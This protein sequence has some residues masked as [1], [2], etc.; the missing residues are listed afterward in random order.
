MKP[1]DPTRRA[2]LDAA[3][4]E[5]TPD[6]ATRARVLASVLALGASAAAG[7]AKAASA[8]VAAGGVKAGL[9]FVHAL[10]LAGLAVAGLGAAY[11]WLAHA[12]AVRDGRP[13]A[14]IAASAPT[15]ASPA[16]RGIPPAA[17]FA[18]GVSVPTDPARTP[19]A[20]GPTGSSGP[21]SSVNALD[22]ELS[23]LQGAHRAYR[24]GQAGSALQLAQEHARLF[25]R[26]Q[27]S[28]ERQTIEVLSLC[29]LGRT[30]EARAVAGKLRAVSGSPSL[31]GLDASCAGK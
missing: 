10:L 17:A 8:T 5:R 4:R 26:S 2:L 21:P 27:L 7:G 25:P 11:L 29:A 18:S 3:N 22:R 31:A 20:K 13:A 24:A 14:A 19:A 23:L 28:A 12:P 9:G 16:P 6:A 1:I 15:S 30:R